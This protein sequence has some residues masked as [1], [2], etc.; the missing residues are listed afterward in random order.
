MKFIKILGVAAML[1]LAGMAFVGATS[2]SANIKERTVCKVNQ[3]LCTA[4]NI[5]RSVKGVAKEARLLGTINQKCE[6][7]VVVEENGLPS[8]AAIP[9]IVLKN[10]LTFTNCTPC[11][12]ITSPGPYE[13]SLSSMALITGGSAVLKGCPFGVNC[14][15]G[16]ASGIELEIELAADGSVSGVLAS[17]EA[18]TLEEGSKLLCGATGKWDALYVPSESLWIVPEREVK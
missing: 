18:L 5:V 16:K 12:E 6:S 10:A 2:A 4:A 17:E 3:K 9:V 15:F 14:K 7:S 13:G 1:A 11:T 8:E